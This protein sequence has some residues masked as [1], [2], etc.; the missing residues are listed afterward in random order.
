MT[1]RMTKPSAARTTRRGVALLAAAG[2]SVTL[3]ACGSD[4]QAA[5]NAP[6]PEASTSA[7]ADT[8]T[9]EQPTS[10]SPTTGTT[11]S[12]DAPASADAVNTAIDTALAQLP[13]SKAFDYEW[14]DRRFEIEI[15][16]GQQEQEIVVG[17]DGTTVAE[18]KT[19]GVDRDDRDELVAAQVDMKQAIQ[20]ALNEQAG[21]AVSAELDKDRNLLGNAPDTLAWDIE[22]KAQDGSDVDIVIDAQSAEVLSKEIDR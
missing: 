15:T 14:D 1:I 12:V 13:N 21:V 11:G 19:D 22:L 3:A 9:T 8:P 17:E 18:T 4:D 7:P 16:D 20:V 5:E 2:L 6:A 10:E